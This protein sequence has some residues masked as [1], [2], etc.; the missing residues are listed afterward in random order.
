MAIEIVVIFPLIAWW[1]FP[2]QNVSS[3]EGNPS[4][5]VDETGSRELI[6]LDNILRGWIG[7]PMVG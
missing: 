4:E 6:N 3:P 7:F 1:I 2:W 5:E